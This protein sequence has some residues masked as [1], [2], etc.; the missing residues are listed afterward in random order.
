M[1]SLRDVI[2]EEWALLTATNALYPYTDLYKKLQES[3]GRK[4][5]RHVF[6]QNGTIVGYFQAVVYPLFKNKN[7]VYLPYGPTLVQDVDATMLA[8]TME[9]LGKQHNAV[10]VRIDPEGRE[11]KLPETSTIFYRSVYHQPRGEWILDVQG[12]VDL[13][14][15]VMHKKTRYNVNKADKQGM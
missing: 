6:E 13:L 1:Y 9:G 4:V 15:S 3:M 10:V 11:V 2:D 7:L 8:K 12:D 14:L 5:V